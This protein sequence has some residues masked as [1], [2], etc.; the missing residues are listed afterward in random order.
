[1]PPRSKASDPLG[2]EATLWDAANKLRGNM[3]AAE[4]K[5]VALGLIF[6]KYVSDA[7]AERRAVLEAALSD[8]SSDEYMEDP[9]DREDTLEDRDEYLA[10][11]VFWIPGEAR[12]GEIQASAKQPDIGRRID[13]AM[14]AIERENPRLRGVLPKNYG[15]QELDVR[16]LGE[17][18]DLIG[19]IGLGAAEHR[20][21]DLLGRVYE[22]FLGQFAASEGKGGG[23]FYTPRSVVRLLVEMLEPFRGRVYDPAA[24]SGGM[25]VQAEDFVLAHGGQRDAISVYGQESNPTTW[26]IAKMNLALR[27]IEANLGPEW[28]DTFHDDKHPDLRA[29][30]VLA[31]PPFNVSDWGGERLRQDPRWKFGVP[32]AGNAN[33]AWLEHIAAH[34][35]PTGRAAIILANGSTSSANEAERDI[36]R[37][38][39]EGGLVDCVMRLPTKLFYTRALSVTVWFLRRGRQTDHVLFV[40]A[41]ALGTMVTRTHR[42]LTDQDIAL[43]HDTYKAWESSP[44][45]FAAVPGFAKSVSAGDIAAAGWTLS[46]NKYVG[47][48]LQH[49]E[50]VDVDVVLKEG[51]AT[52]AL[53]DEE[54]E[55]LR[56]VLSDWTRSDG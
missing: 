36:R 19:G 41:K 52:L 11:N 45:N 47:L 27:G 50:D 3:D 7:F 56:A 35:S 2:I 48:S 44:T 12:W 4:Y 8:P 22:Y 20:E 40:N 13:V 15:R 51:L 6:L 24:G 42:E 10:E 26:R 16:R 38:M 17:L 43:L 9:A 1:M 34:L 32:P 14:D 33:F 29:D 53:L 30:F 37:H 28:G 39:I 49:R 5:H 46:P 31:N 21:M 23:E 25:F 18:V 54:A 55:R